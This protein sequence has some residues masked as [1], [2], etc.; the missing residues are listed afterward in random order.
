VAG[1]EGG[2]VMSG[3]AGSG[4]VG[5]A[6]G[7]GNVEMPAGVEDAS[8]EGAARCVAVVLFGEIGEQAA[9]VGVEGADV[10]G[11]AV[12]VYLPVAATGEDA[13]GGRDDGVD[14]V[15]LDGGA[16][17]AVG[18]RVD[19]GVERQDNRAFLSPDCPRDVALAAATA[20]R[21][22]GPLPRTQPCSLHKLPDVPS[23]VIVALDDAVIRA[24][25]IIWAARNR[26]G[27]E[28]LSLPGGHSPMLSQ[29]AAIA[30]M[31]DGLGA[32]YQ[33]EVGV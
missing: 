16:G 33:A 19:V 7:P 29:P 15:R 31:L 3:G 21:P 26:L 13:V 20:L 1:V 24:E 17:W 5:L 2:D 4:V 14:A 28:P 22:Q 30:Q 12:P 8:A 6:V 10:E 11:P 32:R 27:V 23:T 9:A 18:V 25:W